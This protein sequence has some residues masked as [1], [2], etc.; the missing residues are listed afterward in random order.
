MTCTHPA[1]PET[2]T[3]TSID[4]ALKVK[5]NIQHPLGPTVE[6]AQL[7]EAAVASHKAKNISGT[8]VRP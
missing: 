5:D 1:C 2:S 6:G 7:T 8:V 4:V 3:N